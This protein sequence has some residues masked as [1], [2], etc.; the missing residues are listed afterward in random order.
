MR[1]KRKLQLRR[2]NFCNKPGH[3]KSTC[4]E[5]LMSQ[6]TT[7]PKTDKKIRFF[8]HT[9]EQKNSDTV[10]PHLVNLKNQQG[11]WQDMETASPDCE[12]S[13]WE[14]FYEEIKNQK[15]TS[16]V[17]T[18]KY[19]VLP[20]KI[21]R[22]SEP[23]AKFTETTEE[24]IDFQKLVAEIK[25]EKKTKPQKITA[26]PKKQSTDSVFQSFYQINW[27][28]ALAGAMV[29][30]IVLAIPMQTKTF[31]QNLK[32]S[33]GK[34][35]SDST[36]GF[37]ALQNSTAAIMSADLPTAQYSITEALQKFN[38]AIDEI[39]NH[40]ILQVLATSLPI[41]RS[42]VQSRQNLITAGQKIALGNTYL[43]KGISEANN[44]ALSPLARLNTIAIHLN[45]S[46]P[47]YE[48]AFEDLNNIKID[49]LP[50]EYQTSFKDFKLLFSSLL[51][52]LKN[53]SELSRSLNE[54]F[55]GQGT[56]SYLLVFQNEAEIRPT[57]GFLGSFAVIEIKDGKIVK[58]DIPAGG[59]YDLQ[60]QLSALVEPPT[61]LLLSNKKWEFQDANWFPDF[62]DSAEKML[63]FY[64]YSRNTTLDG[65]IAVNSSV[66]QRLIS[67]VGPLTDE[68]RNLSLNQMNVI[69][70][71]Q[72]VVEEG[73]EKQI[74]KPKQILSDLAPQ[75]ISSLVNL[76]PKNTLPMLF[77]LNEALDQKEIQAYFVASN[78]QK[79]IES[80]GWA[81]RVAQI[82]ND[83]D[84]LMVVNSNIQGQK[85]DLQ[86]KQQIYHQALVD[87]D[88]SIID[89]VTIT[90]EHEGTMG[91]KFYGQTNIDY[92]RLYVPRGAELISAHGF[93]WPDEK[94]FRAPA[95]GAT[96]DETLSAVEEEV[97]FD[98]IS[99]TR[100]TNEF[101]KTAFG[102]WIITDPGTVST[103]QF[104]Y[105]LPFKA[106]IPENTKIEKNIFNEFLTTSKDISQYQIL[107]Q[108]QSGCRSTFESQVIYPTGWTSTWSDGENSNLALNGHFV[109]EALLKND[110]IWSLIMEKN[111]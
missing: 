78:I 89:S 102:N 8:Y 36:E 30:M 68:T 22:E 35:T 19:F 87:T 37:M 7:Q 63:W 61:P 48:Q 60:G 59:S 33:T 73:P 4:P 25:K 45:S 54:I 64:R 41:V 110:K 46:I 40:R 90:R 82:P 93:T 6:K 96:K 83:R 88:G 98:Q 27:R 51:N 67:L 23:T 58:L 100:I 86:I 97:G 109:S 103:V 77:N 65:V 74:N 71:L 50:F 106:F 44:S 47:N 43:I 111:N 104:I 26:L 5:F 62:K 56:R 99:G 69:S 95:K 18:E 10:S 1:I 42:E 52:D 81:G 38:N 53:I 75:F 79:T 57:G 14:K 108:R 2:C 31:Y 107:V 12:K 92:I 105:R 21:E 17:P 80:F 32:T 13:E 29:A 28:K 9:P 84:Y 11:H 101:G 72:S 24:Y 76:G 15:Q 3:N 49:V 16:A 55:G 70:S 91:Q 39:Q 66:L 94:Y 20:E 34:I 85:S